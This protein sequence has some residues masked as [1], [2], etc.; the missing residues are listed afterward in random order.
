L[1]DKYSEAINS[2]TG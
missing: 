1:T 2:H